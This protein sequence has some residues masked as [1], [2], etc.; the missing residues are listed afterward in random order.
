M[1]EFLQKA[2][3]SGQKHCSRCHRWLPI[4]AFAIRKASSDGR[5]NYCRECHSAWS[6]ARRPRKLVPAPEVDAGFKWCRPCQ[7]IKPLEAFAK[8]RSAKDGYQGHCRDCQVKAYQSRQRAM[9][10]TPRPRDVPEGHKYCCSCQQMKPFSEWSRNSRSSDG[11]QTRCKA[12]ASVAGRREYLARKYAMTVEA[13]NELL[14]DQDG[15]CAICRAAAAVHVDHDH[16]TG[17]VRGML[18]F[19]CNAA[20]GQFDDQPTVLLRAARYLM[21]AV[22]KPAG[23]ISRVEVI[24]TERLAEVEFGTA[25]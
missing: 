22:S 7:Q 19:R 3:E 11:W 5:Q 6:R 1:S 18:C 25:S 12:C 4:E 8:N 15:K 9:G 24:W 14:A 16:E 10:K 2:G 13:A 20:L 21:A 23:E 17:K